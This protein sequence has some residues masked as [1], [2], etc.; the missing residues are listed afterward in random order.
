LVGKM[1]GDPGG[2][3]S[4]PTASI[5]YRL[6]L[7]RPFTPKAQRGCRTRGAHWPSERYVREWALAQAATVFTFRMPCASSSSLTPEQAMVFAVRTV[8]SISKAR[9]TRIRHDRGQAKVESGV[10]DRRVLPGRQRRL[11]VLRGR[12]VF[13][14]FYVQQ[15]RSVLAPSLNGVLPK[16]KDGAKVGRYRLRRGLLDASDGQGLSLQFVRRL[17][18]SRALRIGAGQCARQGHGLA[19][20]VR[21]VTAQAKEIADRDFDLITMF[22]CLHDM[23]VRAVA[24]SMCASW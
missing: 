9:S 17:R 2:A 5:G 22:D 18:L 21:F 20:R 19:I 15:H 4:V 16:L 23:G 11:P 6:G 1:L 8:P 14:P 7:S 24:P 3:F 10:P 12:L 13:P